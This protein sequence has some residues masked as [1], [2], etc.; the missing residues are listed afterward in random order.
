MKKSLIYLLLS[1]F[2]LVGIPYNS[3]FAKTITTSKT[4]ISKV[5]KKSLKTKATSG[6]V[7]NSAALKILH[8]VPAFARPTVRAKI[9]NYAIRHHIKVITPKVYNGARV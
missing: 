3:V 8:H 5:Q 4:K 1:V 9:N 2:L 6:V 7:W